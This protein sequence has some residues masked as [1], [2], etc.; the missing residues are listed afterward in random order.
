V[1]PTGWAWRGAPV[2]ASVVAVLVVDVLVDVL[3]V[4][5]VERVVVQRVA[6]ALVSMVQ[7][8]RLRPGPVT[9]GSAAEAVADADVGPGADEDA[10]GAASGRRT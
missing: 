1:A 3:V 6:P 5:V 10:G 2:S 7:A 9:G 8:G 4:V